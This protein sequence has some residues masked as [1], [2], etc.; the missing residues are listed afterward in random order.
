MTQKMDLSV[1]SF[2]LVY[3]PLKLGTFVKSNTRGNTKLSVCTITATA[4]CKGLNIK[5]L[6]SGMYM[7]IQ[8]YASF[9]VDLCMCIFIK[10]VYS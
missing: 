2:I 4:V 6:F 7:V 8:G 1:K 10:I 5:L 9:V 3:V